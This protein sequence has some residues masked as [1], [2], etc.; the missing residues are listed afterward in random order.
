M[1]SEP[2]VLDAVLRTYPHT[3]ALK[4]GALRS[5]DVELR[6]TEVEPVHEAFAPMVRRAAYDLSELAIVV[7]LQ[8]VAYHRPVVLLPAVVASRLQRGCLI[9]H[10]AH[11]VMEPSALV[12]A[13]IGI[14]A[15]TQTTAM[16]VRAHLAEDYGLPIERMRWLTRDPSHVEEYS[17]PPIVEPLTGHANLPDALRAGEIDAAILGSDLP[18]DEDFA[19][20]IPDYAAV[21]RAWC[22]RHGFMPINHLVAVSRDAAREQAPAVRA[23]YA[24]IKRAAAEAPLPADGMQR[25]MF[26]FDRLRG[27]VQETIDTCLRQLL[28]PRP[29]TADEVFAEAR[30]LLGAAGD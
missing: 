30:D 24:L 16:W 27:P 23:A 19:P 2:A 3:A 21:D 18:E 12:R 26:G 1:A 10:R 22:A 13:R 15:Y 20:V 28:L 25:T 4:S 9:Y 29:M 17:D 7:A 6:F 5:P 8:A 11:G 14:R